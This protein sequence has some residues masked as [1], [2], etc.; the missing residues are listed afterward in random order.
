MAFTCSGW[1]HVIGRDAEAAEGGWRTCE[2]T[3]SWFRCGFCVCTYLRARRRDKGDV[4]Q[5]RSGT[6]WLP[7]A[8]SLTMG[9]GDRGL[10]LETL[11][12]SSYDPLTD[13]DSSQ[14]THIYTHLHTYTHTHTHTHTD[15]QPLRLVSLALA[16]Q[17]KHALI[18]ISVKISTLSFIINTQCC[19]WHVTAHRAQTRPKDIQKTFLEEWE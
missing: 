10:R 17:S 1:T 3:K 16:L 6:R 14:L 9:H 11:F 18:W 8:S 15:R 2:T 19:C 13:R 5:W 7:L 12:C 4:S